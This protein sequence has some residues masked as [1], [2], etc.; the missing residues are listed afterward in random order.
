MR[1]TDSILV[2]ASMVTVV[3][4]EENLSVSLQIATCIPRYE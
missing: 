3:L 1:K 2:M 4:K